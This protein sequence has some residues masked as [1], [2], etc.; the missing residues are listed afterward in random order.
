VEKNVDYFRKEGA[1]ITF[2]V[3][4]NGQPFWYTTQALIYQL[5]SFIDLLSSWARA[6]F[7]PKPATPELSTIPDEW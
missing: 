4:A 7:S 5:E 6:A 1:K 2:S 3:V